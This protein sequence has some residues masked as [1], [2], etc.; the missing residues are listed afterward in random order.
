MRQRIV[1][2]MQLQPYSHRE[3][4]SAAAAFRGPLN[5]KCKEA[6]SFHT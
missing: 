1:S 4:E 5:F 6:S 3:E 2:A